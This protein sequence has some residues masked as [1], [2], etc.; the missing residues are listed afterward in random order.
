M[1]GI[2]GFVGEVPHADPLL[3]NMAEALAHRGPDSSGIS[4]GKGFGVAHC[5]LAI[6]DTS[7]RSS[8]PIATERFK[9]IYNGE[10]YNWKELRK[11]YGLDESNVSSDTHLLFQLLQLI[12]VEKLLLKLRGIYAFAFIDVIQGRT[13]LVRDRFGTKPLY[14][15]YFQGNRYYASEIK[16]FLSISGW[17]PTINKRGLENYLTFQNN[18]GRETIF[19]G[20][21][22][23]PAGSVA[24]ISH[25]EP[26][27]LNLI[28]IDFG[29]T[30]TE[31]L[32]DN[33]ETK[34]E[35]ARLLKQAILRNLVADVETGGFLS[36][37]IDSTLIAA[38]SSSSVEGFKTFTIGFDTDGASAY[39]VNF[40]ESVRAK[41]I[42][43]ILKTTHQSRQINS[44]HMADVVDQVSW[45]V[46]DPR[47]GQSYPNLFAS[48]LAAADLRVC[49]AG[50][51]GDE[52]FAGYP[53]RYAPVLA[54]VNREDQNNTILNFW[55]RLGTSDEISKLLGISKHEH[56]SNA[57]TE[58]SQVFSGITDSKETLTLNDILKFEQKTFLH[59]LLLVEDKI[60][61]SQ[62]LEVRV[63]FL[64]DDL[65][66]FASKLPAT[67][68]FATVSGLNFD[69]RALSA[70][71]A[72][73]FAKADGKLI[74]RDVLKNLIPSI[75]S[76]K[77]Q[78]FSAPDATWFKDDRTNLVKSRLLNSNST[79]WSVLNFE[80]GKKLVT[81][82][83]DGKVNRRLLIWSLLTLESTLRQFHF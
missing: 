48:Q 78:G 70:S 1:C 26:D 55:H 11:E 27:A 4:A 67:M 33:Q 43:E 71:V 36:G 66:N 52:I 81:E 49:L 68:K 9:L 44:Q 35:A 12:P 23:I 6:I 13:I 39:E 24:R 54:H 30:S 29:D 25:F 40:D 2:A 83:L 65:V 34:L 73:E 42:A 46:E 63:P 31:N 64:D 41:E 62:G 19:E 32:P 14:T 74:L 37:G 3:R 10:I 56:D 51:G 59:G 22:I 28:S 61:M 75:A 72:K 82:H 80:E 5:R 20:V 21:E 47:V 8:Q 16:A 15:L 79:I 58:V 77:K 57:Q 18:F 17:A 76:L 50:T 53:W 7:L 38:L 45:A 69:E 60:S